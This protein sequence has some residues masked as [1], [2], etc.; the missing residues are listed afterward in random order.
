MYKSLLIGLLVVVLFGS[1]NKDWTSQ[2]TSAQNRKPYFEPIPYGMN[3]IK[4][5]SMNIGPSE[6]EVDHTDTKTK[7]ISV[8]SFWI[9]DTEIT[10]NEYRQ[11]VYWVRDSI[12]RQLLSETVPEFLISE[13]KRGTIMENPH[14]NWQEP[15]NWK[16][17]DYQSTLEEMYLPEAER[18]FNGKEI[19]TRKLIFEYYWIDYRQAAKRANSY[20]YLTQKYDGN[21]TDASGQEAPIQ[22]RSSFIMREATPVY[23]DTLVWIR[24]YTFSYNEPLTKKY[25]SHVAYDNYP[26]VGVTWEQAKAFCNWRTRQM[27]D[28]QAMIKNPGVMDYRLPSEVEWEYAARGGHQM[29]LYPWGSY[30]TRNEEGSYLANFKPLRGNYVADSQ[31]SIATQKV[32]NYLPNSYG[33]YDMAGN[34]AEWTTNAYDESGYEIISDFSPDFQYNAKPD[35]QPALKRKVIRGG[36]WKDI[37]YFIQVSTRSY[38]YQDSAKSYIGFRCV[39]STFKPIYYE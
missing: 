4:Q 39:R 5:G 30:Y 11:F 1:C 29:T 35:D 38:E 33:L 23:P 2:L 28:F 6:Q 8:P 18:F 36:S 24:D 9:D 16:N 22:N 34:V 13:G 15:I 27:N 10:N 37:A 17:S 12:A 25:F 21:V 19:D 20:N 14:L 3:F 26:V 31:T 7:T 32:A